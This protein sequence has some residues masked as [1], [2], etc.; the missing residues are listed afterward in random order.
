MEKRMIKKLIAILIIITIL[1]AD[2]F[3][4]GSGLISYATEYAED[5]YADI[6]FLAYFENGDTSIEQSIR[7]QE[8]KLYAEVTIDNEQAYLDDVKLSLQESNFNIKTLNGNPYDGNEIKLNRIDSTSG[9]K[10]IELGIEPIL[11]EKITSDM[12]LTAKVQLDAKYKNE[13]SIEGTNAT[14]TVEIAVNYQPDENA[15]PELETEIITNKIFT[16]NDGTDKRIVQL[17][18]KSRLN[19]NHYPIKETKLNIGATKIDGI[20]VLPDLEKNDVI[21]FGNPI[22]YETAEDGTMEIRIINPLDNDKKISWDKNG[23]DEVIITYIYEDDLEVETI[24]IET[25]SQIVMA[26]GEEVSSQQL[27]TAVIDEQV[28]KGIVNL[29]SQITTLEMYKGQLYANA[30]ATEKKD[31]TFNTETTLIISNTEVTSTIKVNEGT[32]V[33]VKNDQSEIEAKTKYVSTEINIPQMLE[34]LGVNGNITIKNGETII[35]NINKDT[36]DEDGDGNIVITYDSAD[37]PSELTFETGSGTDRE[38]GTI[39]LKHKKVILGDQ[40]IDRKALQEVKELKTNS[41]VTGIMVVEKVDNKI[42]ENFTEARLSLNE[43]MSKATL[44]VGNDKLLKT[45]ETTENVGLTIDLVTNGEKY[46]LY[47][48]PKITLQFPQVVENVEVESINIMNTNNDTIS[49]KETNWNAERKTLNISVNGEQT[50]Y[51]TTATQL[52]IPLKLSITVS[53]LQTTQTGEITMIYSNENAIQYEGETTEDGN[54]VE[55]GKIG[56][57]GPG[58]LVTMYNLGSDQTTSSDDTFIQLV[59][60]KAGQTL[61]FEIVLFNDTD[62]EMNAVKILGKLPTTGITIGEENTLET[63]LDSINAEGAK[64][65]YTTDAAADIDNSSSWSE[66]FSSDAKMYLIEIET[67]NKGIYTANVNVKVPNTIT[68]SALSYTGYQVIYDRD[69]II[70]SGTIG[71]ATSSVAVLK[72]TLKAQV[73]GETL[74]NGDVVKEG[75]VIKYIVTVENKEKETLQNVN[76]KAMI[77]DGTVLVEPMGDEDGDGDIDYI[78]YEGYYLEKTE[79]KEKSETIVLS[80]SPFTMEY[81]VRVNKDTTVGE[82]TNQVIVTYQGAKNESEII[83][84]PV[85]KSDIRVTAKN[86]DVEEK[87]VPNSLLEYTVYIENL[88]NKKIKDLQLQIIADNIEYVIMNNKQ[89]NIKNEKIDL[90]EIEAN[91]KKTLNLMAKVKGSEEITQP[92]SFVADVISTTSV[93]RSNEIIKQ[94]KNANGTIKLSSNPKSGSNIKEG[95]TVKY[96]IEIQNT[97]DTEALYIDRNISEYLQIQEIKID[98]KTS[99]KLNEEEFIPNSAGMTRLDLKPGE[100]TKI[101]IITKV[102]ATPKETIAIANKVKLMYT[103][104][105]E[106]TTSNEVTH[107][108]MGSTTTTTNVLNTISGL[109][110]LDVNTNGQKDNNEIG[111]KNIILKVYDVQAKSYLKDSNGATIQAVTNDNGEYTLSGVKDGS[112]KIVIEDNYESTTIQKQNITVDGQTKQVIATDIINVQD[113]VR[114]INIGLKE[115]NANNPGDNNGDNN[116]GNNDDNNPEENGKLISGF[117]WLDED[118]DGKKD[119]AEK[120]MSGIKVRLYSDLT[121]NYV[122]DE[123]GKIIEAITDEN[124]KYTF[125]NVAN[126]KYI[127]LFQYDM[128]EYEVTKYLNDGDSKVVLKT[129]KIN[130]EESTFA[131]TDIINVQA[132]IYNINLGLREKL[133]FDLELNKY[134]SRIVVQNSKDTKTYNYENKTLAKVEIHKKRLQGSLVVL[135]YTIKI[136]NNGE[137]AGYAK[138]VVDYLPSGLTFS[139]ELNKD[140]YL[141]GDYLHTKGLEN[142]AINPGEEKEVKL[143]LTKAM[144]NKNTGLINNRAEIYQDYNDYGY[145]DID[146]TPNN[147]I[148]NEDDLGSVDVIIGLATGGNTTLYIILLMVNIVLIGIAIR[149]MFKNNIIKISTKK[150]RR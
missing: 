135:E 70:N 127:V 32:D 30:T 53:K 119:S 102:I 64:I 106:I 9:K 116:G 65:L 77:P 1:S 115:K 98:G 109:V 148:Q 8:L 130:G 126:G 39:E 22:T 132:D 40:G 91:S 41:S 60:E 107:I 82:I 128:E 15:T 18:I 63:E 51:P 121:E 29:S 25:D 104:I 57:S 7:N 11:S 138:N 76:I 26:N 24:Q 13:D 86:I 137:V 88:S 34:V 144:T 141:S 61:N 69:Q 150:E 94:F 117:A 73:G 16:L 23:Y 66:T 145:V 142:I 103:S 131:V 120:G 96:T 95:D 129:I 27:V 58:K 99:L 79:V 33:F 112:Y 75:E 72:T 74:E 113:H 43:T 38:T 118:R 81:E 85:E 90:G 125:N 17:L 56:I 42:V 108:L 12:I 45:G 68:E 10:K 28:A 44:I 124:G 48:N 31:I 3:I 54:G 50:S 123:N 80:E 78:Y 67:L 149:L 93:Y 49:I 100:S 143:I 89:Y 101:E 146:S 71:L 147:Q 114:N 36:V 6:Q 84:N 62:S 134:I 110:W 5:N 37:L 19:D 59:T 21:S 133:I 4:L 14:K 2:F 111:I 139:S 97:G 140:W 87:V 136:K 46:D 20:T 105:Y 55:T 47:K 92:L 52:H 122:K 35:T 83:K